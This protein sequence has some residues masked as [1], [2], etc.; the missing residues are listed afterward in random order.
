MKYALL[1]LSL[2]SFSAL[3]ANDCLNPG[4][5]KTTNCQLGGATYSMT[6]RNCTNAQG[7]FGGVVCLSDNDTS[8]DNQYMPIQQ[9]CG[10]SANV[11]TPIKKERVTR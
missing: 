9:C 5:V 10:A 4:P 8:N 7:S 2:F 3:A 11:S 1:M 6:Y